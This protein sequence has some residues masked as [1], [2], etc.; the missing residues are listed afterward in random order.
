MNSGYCLA[1]CKWPLFSEFFTP[2]EQSLIKKASTPK[3]FLT[4]FSDKDWR[5]IIKL[6]NKAEDEGFRYTSIEIIK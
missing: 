3:S 4:I 1:L 5:N 6:K 2:N